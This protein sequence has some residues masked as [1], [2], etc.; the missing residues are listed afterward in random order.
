MNC[1]VKQ[2]HAAQL[3][4]S[5]AGVNF[6]HDSIDSIHMYMPAYAINSNSFAKS[7][8][9]D[10]GSLCSKFSLLTVMAGSKLHTV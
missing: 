5:I 9:K 7:I 1:D 3:C 2:K 8:Y 10:G 6:R 4:F